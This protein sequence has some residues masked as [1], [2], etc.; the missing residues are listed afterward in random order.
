MTIYPS[1]PFRLLGMSLE[2]AAAHIVVAAWRPIPGRGLTPPSVIWRAAALC[3]AD[4]GGVPVD[5]VMGRG[6][7]SAVYAA[8]V[9]AWRRLY[10]FG[11]GLA[12]IGRRVGRDH[13][14]I[15]YALKGKAGRHAVRSGLKT[16]DEG[17]R[18]LPDD[19]GGV[20]GIGS[21]H[22]SP[23]GPQARAEGPRLLPGS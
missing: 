6:R 3:E 23:A 9:R 21:W 14:S 22:G 19:A 5:A 18:F 13:S 10:A 1:C 15:Y 16:R 4:A 17:G 11:Y 2:L 8:R 20:D 12:P 7:L